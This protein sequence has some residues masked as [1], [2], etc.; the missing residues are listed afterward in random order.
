M[1]SYSTSTLIMILG[2]L[3]LATFNS[4]APIPDLAVSTFDA[5]TT[6]GCIDSATSKSPYCQQN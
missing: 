2:V 6:F 3:L 4:A 1:K 5:K